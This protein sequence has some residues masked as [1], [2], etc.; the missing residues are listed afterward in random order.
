MMAHGSVVVSLLCGLAA[1]APP[2]GAAPQ[3]RAGIDV[4]LTDSSNLLTGRRIGLLTNQTGVDGEG[5]DDLTRLLEAGAQVTAI[6]SPEHGYRGNIDVSEIGDTVE[7]ATGIPIFSLYGMTRAPTP[8]MLR[9]VDVLLADMQDIGARPYTYVSTILLTMRAAAAADL[10]VI[11]LDRPNPLGGVQ[12]QGP[13]LDTTF[14][15]FVGMLPVPLRHGMTMGELVRFGNA[16]LAIGADLTVVPAAGWD[17][18]AWFDATGLP[19]VRP[20]PNMPNLESATHYPGLVLFE[21]TALSVGR[22]TPVAFQVIGA[23]WLEGRAL[24][25]AVGRLPGV[26]LRDTTIVPLDPPDAKYGGREISAIR[27]RVTDRDAYDPVRTAVTLLAALAHRYGDSLRVDES[28]MARLAGTDRLWRDVQRGATPDEIVRS[29]E[30]DRARFRSQRER[31]L[32]YR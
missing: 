11:V 23:P 25:Q 28:R 31:Y 7:A 16:A 3:V 21:A 15:S 13:I 4:L 20:S 30:D 17:R 26:Q 1:C 9:R 6:F 2:S 24:L 5:V 10:P 29:W 22:G 27:F 32:L 14:E 18:T 8:D 19:W 12:V